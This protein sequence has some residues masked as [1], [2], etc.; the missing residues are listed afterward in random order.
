MQVLQHSQL[1]IPSDLNH[2]AR[3]LVWFEQLKLPQ[4]PSLIWLQCQTALAE[5]LT[6]AVRHAHKEYSSDHHI[7][8]EVTI[9]ANSIEIRVWDQG[10]DFDLDQKIASLG[11]SVDVNAE[12]GRGLLMMRQLVDRISYTRINDNRNCLLLVKAYP[13]T[14]LIS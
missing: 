13:P 6:N 8:V 9:F 14:P 11:D 2:L 5:G 4:I 10:V 1:Q 3:V 12:G 7:E